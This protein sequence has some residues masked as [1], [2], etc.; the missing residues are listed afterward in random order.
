MK[1]EIISFKIDLETSKFLNLITQKTG[2]SKSNIIRWALKDFLLKAEKDQLF[3]IYAKEYKA[4]MLLENIKRKKAL[5][6]IYKQ[7]KLWLKTFEKVL[8][9]PN[10]QNEPL[11][12]RFSV[13]YNNDPTLLK[14]FYEAQKLLVE[15]M[16]DYVNCLKANGVKNGCKD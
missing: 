10:V 8:K 2:I 1:K 11:N 5:L 4:F 14:Q 12:K 7:S 16:E 15:V 6:A 9:N 13:F 3:E